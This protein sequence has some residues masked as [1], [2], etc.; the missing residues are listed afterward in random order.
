MSSARPSAY[1]LSDEEYDARLLGP[2]PATGR[3]AMP[4]WEEQLHAIGQSYPV[5]PGLQALA[6]RT[7]ATRQP[8]PWQGTRTIAEF[9][10][11]Q[12]AGDIALEAATAIPMPLPARVALATAGL[13]F[14]NPSEAQGGPIDR[15][16][17]RAAN[18]VARGAE[19]AAAGVARATREGWGGRTG[20]PAHAAEEGAEAAQRPGVGYDHP[21]TGPMP[22]QEVALPGRVPQEAPTTTTTSP[23][24]APQPATPP[25]QALAPE[26]PSG[27]VPEASRPRD[28][29]P[30]PPP[31]GAASPNGP[32][33]ARPEDDL[34]PPRLIASDREQAERLGE[35]ILRA[36][37]R[38]S[39]LPES[40]QLQ[41]RRE[42]SVLADP[43]PG[44][45][46]PG[47]EQRAAHDLRAALSPDQRL[48]AGGQLPANPF[49]IV[50]ENIGPIVD[51][52]LA[53]IG[54]VV[55]RALR[56]EPVGHLTPQQR[57]LVMAA[58][59]SNM[60]P[61][62][63]RLV[64]SLGFTP[65]EAL[66][67][68]LLEARRLA[69]TSLRSDTVT[70]LRSGALLGQQ[71]VLLSPGA[72][73]ADAVRSATGPGSGFHIIYGQH[74]QLFEAML[75][76]DASL[77]RAPKIGSYARSLSGDFSAVP[78]DVHNF[79]AQNMIFNDLHPGQLPREAFR[80]RA[81]YEQ[82]QAAYRSGPNGSPPLG[83]D[84]QDLRQLMVTAPPVRH[85][86]GQALRD[87]YLIY[88]DG[89]S[90][91]ARRAG[92]TPTEAQGVM[93]RQYGGDTGLASPAR[94]ATQIL[95]D[96]ISVTAQAIGMSP[97]EVLSLYARNRIPLLGT[98]GIAGMGPLQ[99]LLGPEEQARE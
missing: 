49:S 32:V 82:Y 37:S 79:R 58:Q 57:E 97:L 65:Q 83:M 96:R 62:Y 80:T 90:E 31:A 64:T 34:T 54:P 94:T 43:R 14:G 24:A 63:D 36:R 42:D 95:D 44:E 89:T 23:A 74:P 71:Q 45:R 2:R 52:I 87:T 59:F 72:S 77:A 5:H 61:L 15:I 17:G 35:E 18:A 30:E 3:S 98:A 33:G 78:V 1:P 16:V 39:G 69:A 13:L 92:I 93:W 22:G 55:P 46:L 6:A 47:V 26:N 10:V 85:V 48:L 99:G 56:G 11:P 20:A 40:Q 12:N 27:A 50:A 21:P 53:D 9:L 38:Q 84:A 86:D 41:P 4:S 68:T 60:R 73:L 91:F 66:D 51:R 75:R 88:N 76:G 29:T 70:N 67:R 81:G 19:D 28:T 8:A 25:S 7:R